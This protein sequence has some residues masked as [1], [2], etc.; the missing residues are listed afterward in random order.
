MA[1]PV[2]RIV[3]LLLSPGIVRLRGTR[4]PLTFITNLRSAVTENQPTKV[5]L[6]TIRRKPR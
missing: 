6:R 3:S 4:S 1:D 5:L 2:K